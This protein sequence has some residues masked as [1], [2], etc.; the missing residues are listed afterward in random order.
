[1][2][3]T[4][5]CPFVEDE[6]EKLIKEVFKKPDLSTVKKFFIDLYDNLK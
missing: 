5:T 3:R 2:I 6:F 4:D 1:M